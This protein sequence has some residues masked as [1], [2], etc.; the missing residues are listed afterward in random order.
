MT[1][2]DPGFKKIPMSCFCTGFDKVISPKPYGAIM[3][4]F[5]SLYCLNKFRCDKMMKHSAILIYIHDPQLG[6][7]S[8][9][10]CL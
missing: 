1:E 7:I 5:I 4:T 8:K 10:L 6:D 9:L 3:L 2:L